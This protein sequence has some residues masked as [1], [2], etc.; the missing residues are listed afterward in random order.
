MPEPQMPDTASERI[1]LTDTAALF[2]ADHCLPCLLITAPSFRAVVALQGAQ[3]LSY[4]PAGEPDWLWLSP[5][6]RFAPGEA[7]RGGIP[8]CAPWF[9]VNRRRPSL[10]KHGFLRNR[11]WQWVGVDE[12]PGDAVQLRLE[13]HSLPTDLAEF[14]WPFD[15]ELALHF[16]DHIVMTLRITNRGETPMPLSFA[17]HSYF[18]TADLT[19]VAVAELADKRYLDNTA[20]L[21]E[22]V[23]QGPLHFAGEVDRVYP[24]VASGLSLGFDG[25]GLYVDGQGCDTAILW[26]PGAQLASSMADVGE[27]YQDYVCLERGMA[28]DDEV[29]LSPG[30][31]HRAVMTIGRRVNDNP[32]GPLAAQG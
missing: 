13:C 1:A 8:V 23:Q 4:Q 19:R 24:G 12:G 2:G 14:E 9:G 21:S 7:I 15:A 29:V 5:L 25:S 27:H 28:F 31:A 22:R 10:P 16:S 17:F 3:V 6:A 26:N 30:T 20:G 32:G 11:P 18:R